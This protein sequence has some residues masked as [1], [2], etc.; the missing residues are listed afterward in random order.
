[1]IFRFNLVC[2]L[3]EFQSSRVQCS[4]CIHKLPDPWITISASQLGPKSC[5]KIYFLDSGHQ[6][7][8]RDLVRV[9]GCYNEGG[10]RGMVLGH[11]LQIERFPSTCWWQRCSIRHLSIPISACAT[12]TLRL[13]RC[14]LVL[15][16]ESV[17]LRLN[18][19]NRVFWS[20][21]RQMWDLKSR[22]WYKLGHS[23]DIFAKGDWWWTDSCY[24]LVGV[25]ICD[26]EA[27]LVCLLLHLAT[28]YLW[29]A[30][31]IDWV[32]L[33]PFCSNLSSCQT[34]IVPS[35]I[36]QFMSERSISS[37]EFITLAANWGCTLWQ[38]TIA[39][40]RDMLTR[41]MVCWR[42]LPGT[43]VWHFNP[44]S[45]L[46]GFRHLSSSRCSWYL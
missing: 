42:G 10:E 45:L 23:T 11:F 20:F 43:T 36:H 5:K 21:A 33:V 15:V 27:A 4:C 16:F 9:V 24:S 46:K 26:S 6:A 37:T 28:W 8:S 39:S 1:M 3:D 18:K 44:P 13:G 41:L 29:S 19:P 31:P 14:S 40:K 38:G 17:C 32:V 7:L 25:A 34:T 22:T 12:A 30:S 2:W 35:Q